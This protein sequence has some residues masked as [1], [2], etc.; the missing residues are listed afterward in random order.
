MSNKILNAT[1]ANQQRPANTKQIT[2]NTSKSKP[3]NYQ[4][5]FISKYKSSKQSVEI[6]ILIF[7]SK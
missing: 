6:N 2:N 7:I 4:N 3:N 1:N 5:K